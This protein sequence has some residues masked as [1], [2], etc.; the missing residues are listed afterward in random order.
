M[1][2]AAVVGSLYEAFAQGDMD[3]LGALLGDTH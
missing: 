2:S 3:K 1:T